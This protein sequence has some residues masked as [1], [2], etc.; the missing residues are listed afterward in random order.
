MGDE[1]LPHLF[2]NQRRAVG[3]I[4]AETMGWL[5]MPGPRQSKMPLAVVH[6]PVA[7]KA[8]IVGVEYDPVVAW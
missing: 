7:A 6:A 1:S 5:I 8:G 4:E 2:Q 3:Q